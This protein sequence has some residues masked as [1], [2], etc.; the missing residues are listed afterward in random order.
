MPLSVTSTGEVLSGP[1]TYTSS[2][3]TLVPTNK[4]EIDRAALGK[5][6]VPRNF[7][8]DIKKDIATG[9]KKEKID[10]GLMSALYLFQKCAVFEP[11]RT[12]GNILSDLKECL[13]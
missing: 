1:T 12:I 9:K 6:S 2:I 7:G 13:I 10:R 8:A 11:V 5:P 3:T 4:Q